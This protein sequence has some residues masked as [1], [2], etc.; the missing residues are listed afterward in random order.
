ML[1]DARYPAPRLPL[2]GRRSSPP[3]RHSP[4]RRSVFQAAEKA[5]ARYVRRAIHA[6]PYGASNHE[7][8]ALLQIAHGEAHILPDIGSAGSAS[9]SSQASS[10]T[11]LE[12][13]A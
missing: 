2:P 9:I 12:R 7:P 8:L 13:G 10:S 1:H 11:S 3:E 5:S 6:A 4:A